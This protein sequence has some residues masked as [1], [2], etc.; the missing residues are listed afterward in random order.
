[1]FP[2]LPTGSACRSGAQP[3]KSST[4]SNTLASP[5]PLQRL[6]IGRLAA[7]LRLPQGAPRR[8]VAALPPG[9]CSSLPC[10]RRPSAP[11]WAGLRWAASP[12][13]R[14]FPQFMPN[15]ASHPVVVS[16]GTSD[17]RD[18]PTLARSG[19]PGPDCC[20]PRLHHDAA[21][22]PEQA[23][24]AEGDAATAEGRTAQAGAFAGA[25][26]RN[27]MAGLLRGAQH[28]IDEALGPSRARA[29][30]TPRPDAKILAAS[31]HLWELQ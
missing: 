10:R 11:A 5:N 22:G 18:A 30:N 26:L 4:I 14:T 20:D 31:A 6:R 27:G 7:D 17:R 12:C 15:Q 3:S 29:A 2:A 9:S 23:V 1:M 24:A 21:A 8:P 25:G 19:R 28:L 13:P 16:P